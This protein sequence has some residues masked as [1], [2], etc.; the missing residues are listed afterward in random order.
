MSLIAQIQPRI[1]RMQRMENSKVRNPALRYYGGKF[2]LAPW[3]ISH[4]PAHVTFVEPF[5]GAAGV[6]LRKE[7][8]VIEVYNDLDSEVFNFFQVV[9]ERRGDLVKALWWTPYSKQEHE[10]SFETDIECP[11]E[12]ARRF[13]VRAWQSFGG[14]S[15]EGTGW[16]RQKTLW[17]NNP[18]INQREEWMVAIRNLVRVG[19]RFRKVQ[20]ERDDALKVIQFFDT[21][22][23]LF[24]CDPPYPGE[25]RSRQHRRAYA[26][27]FT[28]FDHVNLANSLQQIKGMAIVSTYPNAHYAELFAGW[29]CVSKQAVTT[30]HSASTEVLYISPRAASELEV[31]CR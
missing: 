1:T 15:T 31:V 20:L 3:I 9:R 17:I 29:K 25:V 12:R 5:G 16:K 26:H 6:L 19:E 18:R 11:L 21:P 24:Y 2:R 7:P 30:S 13:F 23:T 22:A 8:S 14:P 4:F 10:L 27:E 28:A